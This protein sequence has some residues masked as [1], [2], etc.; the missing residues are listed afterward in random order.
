MRYAPIAASL[1]F[2]VE[3]LVPA[4]LAQVPSPVAFLGHE[5]GADHQ[6]CNYTDLVRYFRAIEQS[7]D[8][9]KLVDIGPT[10]YG[11]RMLMAVI[12]SP[13]NHTRLERL[14][15][16]SQQLS[17]GR[18]IDATQAK[19][20]AA[21][22]RAFVWIDGGLHATEAIAGQNIIELVWQMTSR[23][24]A[25]VRRILDE[26]VLLVCPVNPD[27]LELV[28]N[29]YRATRSMTTPVL[30]QR[31]I[32]HDNNRDFYVCNQ[33]EA[34][35]VNRVFY[36]DWCP[37]IVYNHHQS[38]PRGTIIFTP[39]FRDPH[40][41]YVDAMVIRGIE[42]VSAHM[43]QRFAA[44]G[45]PG[46][47][48]RSGAPYSGWWNGGLRSTNYFHNVI[49]IL[50][51]SFGRPEPTQ[52]EQTIERRLPYGD[53]PDPVKSQTWHA[54]QTVEYLQTANFAILDYAARYREELLRQI[55][56]M[57]TRAIERGQRDHWTPTPYLVEAAR[58]RETPESVFSDPYLRD[59]RVYVLRSD[60]PDWSAAQRMVRALRR[61]GVEVLR[62]TA[63]FEA[64][65]VTMPAGSFVVKTDQAY[66]AHVLDQ[67]EP[68]WHPDD[69]KDGKPV[70][71]YDA[72]G[73]TLAMQFDV[74]V[75]RSFEGLDGPFEVVTDAERF[76]PRRL[77]TAG[78]YRLD[79]R[80]SHAV[81]AVNRLLAA[82]V[83]VA[84]ANGGF[85]VTKR[86]DLAVEVLGAAASQLGVV[87]AST[88]AV[89]QAR[90]R[91]VPAR[92]GL[93]D[94]FGGHM[95]T[96]WDQWILK[97]FE[98]PMQQVWGDRI[99]A[100]D[101][102]KDFDVLVFHT[103][104]PG[105]RDLERAARARDEQNLD[106]LAAALPPFEDWSNLKAR[107]TRLTGEKALPAIREF[108]EQGGTLIALAGEC[109]KVIR[110]FALPIK[111]GTHVPAEDGERRTL[112]EE[113]YVPGSL[114]AIEVDTSH[115]IARG[116]SRELAAMVTGSSVIMQVTDP[117]ARIDVVARY[118]ARDTL[119][120]G[121]AIGEDFLLGK[122][123]VL[124][125]HVGKGRVL[126]YGADVTYRGQPLG[127]FK[128]FFHGILT[129]GRQR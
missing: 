123:A 83:E 13:Q 68:Q 48:S 21:E 69:M 76:A 55:H 12:T 124:C 80:D 64:N 93:F 1:F 22:G 81:I 62:A 95:P 16:I 86:D 6:L 51:E 41:Y 45:K 117:N 125:A 59:P 36:T 110:H 120:S 25:E 5:I 26:V 87:A 100:G 63:P 88:P 90:E 70:A 112:R 85:Y 79:A 119:L 129:S 71:P 122:Q 15:T 38:A 116:A 18:G 17:K 11:Q 91:I 8:R 10:S 9:M 99:E 94:T 127:T 74:Q 101:L 102:G 42:I 73:W 67:F 56:T 106:K 82:G 98:F 39:P 115:P 126:L 84:W 103:G 113:Y 3:L 109:D 43:N 118:R 14:R 53:Y 50:T 61:N 44:E 121:W 4:A 92:V 30:Y 29:A 32:G 54:R 52:I 20:L 57:A 77:P 97:E 114:L 49:G 66:R 35:N 104:L 27:G 72:A 40:N 75:E 58:R 24:D 2:A 111:V 105:P 107:A 60:Q 33:L 108:V 34:Q 7:T 65:G 19:A 128:L 28:A 23:D 96:G 37:Q 47:I 31:Y 78:P 46:V 89:P